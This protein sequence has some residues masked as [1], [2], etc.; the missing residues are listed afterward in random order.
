MV[1]LFAGPVSR[2]I[3]VAANQPLFEARTQSNGPP[4]SLTISG[5]H[6]HPTD[7]GG[8]KNLVGDHFRCRTGH[9]LQA[10]MD[11]SMTGREITT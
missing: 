2:R 6:L 9:N 7:K 4:A 1:S 8:L 5:H 11:A 3:E 10:N